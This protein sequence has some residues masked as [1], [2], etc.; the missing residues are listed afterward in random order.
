MFTT[1]VKP[2]RELRNNYPEVAQIVKDQNHVI[3]TNNGKSEAVLISYDEFERY[4]EFL[5]I[6]YVKEKL[7]QAESIAAN[8][9]EWMEIDDLFKEWDSWV[10]VTI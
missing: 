4:Q 9:D 7:A 8:P 10:A 5:H 6:R 2:I 1:H 3:I